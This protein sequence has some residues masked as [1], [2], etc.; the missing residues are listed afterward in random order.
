MA[1]AANSPEFR[2]TSMPPSRTSMIAGSSISLLASMT[3][4]PADE[5]TLPNGCQP[6]FHSSSSPFE[7]LIVPRCH[8]PLRAQEAMRC[9]PSRMS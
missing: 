4:R 9:S 6:M 7:S 1:S 5:A 8:M 3:T 2:S